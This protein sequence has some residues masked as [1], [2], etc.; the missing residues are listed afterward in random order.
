VSQ[1]FHRGVG[2][3]IPLEVGQEPFRLVSSAQIHLSALELRGD[4][5]GTQRRMAGAL[6][7]EDAAADRFAPVQVRA[8]E[9]CIQR[10]LVNPAAE[11]ALQEAAK[12][13]VPLGLRW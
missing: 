8:G 3:G 12:V 7:A 11:S 4:A 1:G 10:D 6:V 13:G 5:Q 2:V 9:V